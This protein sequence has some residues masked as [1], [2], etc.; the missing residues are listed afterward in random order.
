MIKRLVFKKVL[1]DSEMDKKEGDYLGEDFYKGLGENWKIDSDT[2]GYDEEGNLIFIF[3]KKAIP[4]ELSKEAVD[5]LKGAARKRHENRGAAAGSLDRGKMP[6]Y[7]G[8]FIKPNKFRTKFVSATSGIESKQAVSNLSPSNIIGYFDKPDRN[9]KGAGSNIRQTVFLR[10]NWDKWLK[11]IPYE[12]KVN[13]IYRDLIKK[14]YTGGNNPYDEQ[15][16]IAKKVPMCIIGDTVFSTVTINYSWRTAI[17]KDKANYAGGW[18][19]LTVIEDHKNDNTYKGCYLGFPQYGYCVDVR[20]GDI[21]ITD[22]RIGWH[23]NTEIIGDNDEIYP[24]DRDIPKKMPNELEIKNKWFYN[25]FTAVHY[26]RDTMLRAL[27]KDN[28]KEKEN[29]H[30]TK[31]GSLE[32]K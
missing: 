21:L 5:N 18:A 26:L 12:Q 14:L 28:L 20:D 4:E 1:S 27:E 19:V 7:V 32:L 15:E 3:R 29:G 2:D 13:D 23:G 22:N 25:R 11:V 9:L 17:H 30:K 16:K 8:E 24:Y 6:N 10:D 31:T